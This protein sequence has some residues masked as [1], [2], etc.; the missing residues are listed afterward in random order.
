MSNIAHG[1]R[2]I[3]TAAL[4][5]V[6]M[7]GQLFA[8]VNDEAIRAN[9]PARM[10]SDYGLFADPGKQIPSQNVH[11]YDLI[12]PLFTDYASKY[13]FV[14]VPPGRRVNYT[15][16]EVFD[17][18]V[19]TVL[20]KTFAYPADLR[21]PEQNVRLI[22]TRLLI[23]QDTGWRAWAYVW[24]EQ[25]NDAKLKLAGK[26]L[27]V[28][29]TGW[30]GNPLSIDYAVPNANQCKG[31]HA[32]NKSITPIGPNARNLNREYGSQ[33]QIEAW[34]AKGLL[35]DVPPIG[36]VPRAVDWTDASASLDG[37]ARSYL[38]VNCAHCHRDGGAASNSGLFLTDD[39]SNAQSWG[40]LKRPVAAGR[41][42][43]GL[44]YDIEP[45]SPERS[46]LLFRMK[47]L[48]P[49]IMMPEL[50]RSTVHS[51]AIT[52]LEAWIDQME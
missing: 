8:Q 36:D 14:Y 29:V 41:G 23:R 18:P 40:Y 5:L 48:D 30:D 50:G 11:P 22:E 37:R 2:V 32:L 3:C 47:S 38:D 7:F 28:D 9:K 45:G 21:K 52:M 4:M 25:G 33:N 42:S 46:I 6:A 39:E 51:E 10:L 16:R 43:G 24:N 49:G 1:G 20:V 26:R 13:R 44:E 27:A 15:D 34:V 17:F 19:G 31:C 12:T 35:F